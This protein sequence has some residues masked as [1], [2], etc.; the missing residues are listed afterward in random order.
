[1]IGFR[2][3]HPRCDTPGRPEDG[4]VSG[5]LSALL[6]I[7][8]LGLV[9]ALRFPDLLSFGEL[10]ALHAAPFLRRGG[11]QVFAGGSTAYHRYVGGGVVCSACES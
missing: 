6:G 1:M 4:F 10:E 9:L 2:T 3:G 11:S 7:A 5:L 8:G